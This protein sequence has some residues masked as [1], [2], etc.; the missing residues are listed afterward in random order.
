MANEEVLHV[1][2]LSEQFANFE[3]NH[4]FLQTELPDIQDAFS[5]IIL[6]EDLKQ[7]ISAAGY[8]AAAI[9]AAMD[10]E[11]K[12]IEVYSKQAAAS[13]DPHEKKL[14]AWLADW[15]KGH[16]AVLHEL[17]K[18]LKEKIWNDNQFWPF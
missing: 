10:M 17:D 1:K 7:K 12:A 8:E 9:S 16:Y 18:E 6:S 3:K 5:G 4:A 2:F 13:T 14:F 11:T 15:E